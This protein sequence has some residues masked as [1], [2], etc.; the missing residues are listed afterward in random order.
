MKYIIVFFTFLII[1]IAAGLSFY[2]AKP[3]FIM[4]KD[5]NTDKYK[6]NILV[7]LSILCGLVAS[8]LPLTLY[9]P[10]KEIITIEPTP[11]EIKTSAK[12]TTVPE[13]PKSSI[14]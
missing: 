8:I 14:F 1:S 11:L 9:L 6:W 10:Q 12:E 7:L 5:D 13:L 3:E 2:Y 4:K